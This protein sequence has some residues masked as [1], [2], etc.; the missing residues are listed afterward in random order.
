MLEPLCSQVPPALPL[1]CWGW[2]EG[3]LGWGRHR[4]RG[5][6]KEPEPTAWVLLAKVMPNPGGMAQAVAGLAA[7]N[8]SEVQGCLRLENF[9]RPSGG[10]GRKG[11]EGSFEVSTV[12]V[13][14]EGVRGLLSSCHSLHTGAQSCGS[15]PLETPRAWQIPQDDSPLFPPPRRLPRRIPA[16][17]Q[18]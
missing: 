9:C 4:G 8:V 12:G 3:V 10:A 1:A 18:V 6:C 2:R 5:S 17:F 7:Q 13:S 16:F 14:S 11:W 15:E